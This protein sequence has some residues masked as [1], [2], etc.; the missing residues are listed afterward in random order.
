M[1]IQKTIHD[2]S[3]KLSVVLGSF[4]VTD[5]F[6]TDNRVSQ[7]A[8]AEVYVRKKFVIEGAEQA[9]DVLILDSGIFQND[10]GAGDHAIREVMEIDGS[11]ILTLM[12]CKKP[13]GR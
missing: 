13:F 7:I 10:D 5:D 9:G 12:K 3:S 8:M 11:G 2:I 1:S 4:P 6:T